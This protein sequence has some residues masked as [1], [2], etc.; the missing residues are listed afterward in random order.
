MTTAELG[1]GRFGL[2]FGILRILKQLRH[3]QPK[4]F[5]ANVYPVSCSDIAATHSEDDEDEQDE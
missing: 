2:R 5:K 4:I 3:F 1:P